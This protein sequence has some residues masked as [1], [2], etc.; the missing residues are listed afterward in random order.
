MP[1][2]RRDL[3]LTR[4]PVIPDRIPDH[5]TPTTVT[6]VKRTSICGAWSPSTDPTMRWREA[7]EPAADRQT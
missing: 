6:N 2:V 1:A 5:R 3:M 7:G 4:E